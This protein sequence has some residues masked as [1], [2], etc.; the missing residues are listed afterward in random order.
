M[1][2]GVDD[3]VSYPTAQGLMVCSNA[4]VDASVNC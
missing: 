2:S 3:A 1:A 4:S